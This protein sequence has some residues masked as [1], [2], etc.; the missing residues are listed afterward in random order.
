METTDCKHFVGWD[1]LGWT[2]L[3]PKPKTANFAQDD[4]NQ[5]II[6]A[7]NKVSSEIHKNNL[8]GG[9]SK[10][11]AHPNLKPFFETLFYYNENENKF[12]GRYNVEF[13]DEVQDNV[14]FVYCDLE[15]HEGTNG[16]RFLMAPTGVPNYEGPIVH[17]DGSIERELVN[18]GEISF[19]IY[20]MEDEENHEWIEEFSK[21]N[22]GFVSIERYVEREDK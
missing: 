5:T 3:S 16:K 4:W 2:E 22:K 8:R 20:D 17:E 10:I 15:I 14:I 7:I 9:A 1:Y 13:D 18:F 19:K 11:L 6:T 21:L 12:G